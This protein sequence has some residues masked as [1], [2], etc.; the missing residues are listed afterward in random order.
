MFPPSIQTL[1]AQNIGN[2]PD[3]SRWPH[4]RQIVIDQ[5][6]QPILEQDY[7]RQI[8]ALFRGAVVRVR[9]CTFSGHEVFYLGAWDGK[10]WN[11]KTE[12]QI[13]HIQSPEK[14]DDAIRANLPCCFLHVHCRCCPW[15]HHQYTV[16]SSSNSRKHLIW[17]VNRVSVTVCKPSLLSWSGGTRESDP[18]SSLVSFWIDLLLSSQLHTHLYEP[19]LLSYF[20]V[21]DVIPDVEVRKV[22]ALGGKILTISPI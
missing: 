13:P 8:E 2:L 7:H 21:I 17:L 12:Y 14:Q 3:F 18:I 10:S 4:S 5:A 15:P 6:P 11:H 9:S 16:S 20:L 1:N 19:F 22:L